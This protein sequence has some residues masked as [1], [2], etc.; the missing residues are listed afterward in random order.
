MPP[1]KKRITRIPSSDAYGCGPAA[2]AAVAR[3][4]GLHLQVEQLRTLL[5]TTAQGTTLLQLRTV[6]EDLGFDASCGRVTPNNLRRIALPAIAH[7]INGTEGHIIVITHITPR[8]IRILD[9]AKG[10][11]KVTNADFN[12]I[13]T[14]Y[15]VILRP[16]INFRSNKAPRSVLESYSLCR[17][18][19]G[20]PY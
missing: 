9:P 14:G 1:V 20:A 7:I 18:S 19:S 15:V 10:V 13:W 4:Y 8:S 6:A 17:L 12:R 11:R 2:L 3:Y 5:G 16:G